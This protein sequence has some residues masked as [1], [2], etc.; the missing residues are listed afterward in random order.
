M[1]WFAGAVCS[2][3]TVAVVL[4]L[5]IVSFVFATRTRAR[6]T[7]L[8]ERLAALEGRSARVPAA[9]ALAPELRDPL[10]D[11][12]LMVPPLARPEPRQAPAEPIAAS[13]AAPDPIADP[14][15]ADPIAPDP[16]A[17]PPSAAPPTARPPVVP[18]PSTPGFQLPGVETLA[19][20][21]AA[22]LGGLG[23]VIAALFGLALA[24]ERGYVGPP[25]RFALA[26][27]FG[28]GL[29]VAS[30]ALRARRYAVPGGALAGAG[31]AVLY[32][33]I[34]AGHARYGLLA[35]PV[36]MAA[37]VGVTVVSMFVAVRRDNVLLAILATAG[38]FLTPVLLSTGENKAV[39][40]FTYLALLDAGVVFAATRRRWWPVVGLAGV[41]TAV[42]HVGWGLH[43]RAPDQVPVALTSAIGI[44][45]LFLVLPARHGTRRPEA[46][47][48]AVAGLLVL[49]AALLHLPPADPLRTDPVSGLALRW[50]L[51]ATAWLGAAFVLAEAALVSYVFARRD[52]P[53]LRVAGTAVALVAV[54]VYSLGWAFG[55]EPTWGPVILVLVAGAAVAAAAVR[56]AG[57][58]ATEAIAWLGVSGLC[59]LAT[60]SLGAYTEDPH[61]LVTPSNAWLAVLVAGLTLTSALVAFV[62]RFRGSLP[63]GLL[64]ASLPLYPLL[65]A[66]MDAPGTGLLL[67]AAALVYAVHTFPVLW[68]PRAGDLAGT[69]A[70]AAAGP[71]LLLP[72]LEIWEASLGDAASGLVAV[73]LGVP[74]LLGALAL[75]RTVRVR[76]DNRELALLVM[77]TLLFA[78][79]AV[80]IQLDEAWLTVGWSVELALL[81]WL[82]RRLT[83]VGIRVG[84]GMLAVAV[85]VRLLLNPE[86]LHYGGGEGLIILNWT[87][88]TWGIPGVC[89]LL[90]AAWLPQPPWASRALRVVAVLIFFALVNLEVAHAFAHDDALSFTSEN[91]AESMTRSISW[92]AYGLLI[93]VVGFVRDS[94]AARLGGFAFALL[95]A[96]KVCL[97]DVWDL[98]G[99]VRVGSFAGLAVVLILAALV[100]QKVVLRERVP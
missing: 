22:S 44:A 79:L 54:A 29:W 35:N 73:L 17:A 23:L 90:A 38:G 5:P 41:A 39:A 45:A 59:A 47:A 75:V 56:A 63:V 18:P 62:L 24:I 78:A 67:G 48:G 87:L 37:M 11:V 4:G 86:A 88:Y 71:V 84:A 60:V 14:V 26:I 13:V 25:V 89:F 28:V 20:W 96:A 58:V 76:A 100:F 74:T 43:F 99:L 61:A 6:V 57:R 53:T 30:E 1:E 77:V 9:P 15:A 8:E 69:L 16:V 34:Y 82:S 97:V 19:V 49:L 65:H 85:A 98:S 94:R 27:A 55:S 50:A 40:F 72:F 12:P 51:G 31:A 42:L 3:L 10:A 36:A 52:E 33:A 68:R 2:L 81:A 21:L 93:L 92:G 83:Y 95:G 32:G 7:A 66:R 46:F 70:A 80:P 64:A 91:L